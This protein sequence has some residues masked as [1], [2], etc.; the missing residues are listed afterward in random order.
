MIYF[1]MLNTKDDISNNVGN[2]TVDDHNMDKKTMQVN[3][4]HQ[5]LV[6]IRSRVFLFQE[7]IMCSAEERNPYR[8]GRT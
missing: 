7:E 8:I 3:G 2:Q 6:S 5:L 1:F 4:Y